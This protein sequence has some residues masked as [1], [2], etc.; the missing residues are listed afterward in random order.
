MNGMALG[1]CVTI[2]P[3]KSTVEG[4]I[5]ILQKKV[6]QGLAASVLFGIAGPAMA[7]GDL[8]RQDAIVVE[9]E[10]GAEDGTK[11]WFPA[12]WSLRRANSTNSS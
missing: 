6:A 7:E 12:R 11:N 3:I 2:A 10:I 1:R 8:T 9:I 5:N 4:Y